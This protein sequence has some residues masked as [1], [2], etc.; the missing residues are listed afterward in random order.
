MAVRA[1]ILV[2]LCV[3]CISGCAVGPSFSEPSANPVLILYQNPMLVPT[4]DPECVWETVVDVLDDYFRIDIPRTE[5]VR[6]VGT[7][8][9]EGRLETYAEV[10][11]TLFEPWR[12]DSA[13]T[14]EKIESTLQSIR[15][16]AHVRVVPATGG[17]WI[18]V[19]VFK[20]LEDVAH[21]AHAS[22]GS[23][24]F[25]NDSTLTRVVSAVGEQEINEGWISMGRDPALEQRILAQLH[26]RFGLGA[27][28]RV[29]SAFEQPAGVGGTR[30]P[31]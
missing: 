14:Y 8:L 2:V 10:A 28:P 13:D 3:V 27:A 29:Q 11:S 26:E 16:R 21:P 12:H 25:R 31:Y 1:G 15:R 20:E 9:T 23:A 22:A 17:Y 6:L 18:E 30:L 24:T 19:A 7:T 5:P 4:R